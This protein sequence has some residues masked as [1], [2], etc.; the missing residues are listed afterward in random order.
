MEYDGH[1]PFVSDC[2]RVR[3]RFGAFLPRPYREPIE[4]Q[5][6]T[7]EAVRLL[8]ERWNLDRVP[9]V[10]EFDFEILR[11]AVDQVDRR[12]GSFV[13]TP[14]RPLGPGLGGAVP[15][16]PDVSWNGR[17]WEWSLTSAESLGE[18]RDRIAQD[19]DLVPNDLP[20]ELF[21]QLRACPDKAHDLG[22]KLRDL[23]HGLQAH[24]HWL[25]LRL[26]PQPDQPLGVAAIAS[27]ETPPPDQR[28]VR[29]AVTELARSMRITLP[30]LR[31][32]R[33]RNPRKTR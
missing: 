29:R 8:A 12:F 10:A 31:V 4:D 2:R 16:N 15:E 3:E 9:Q 22:W 6:A 17:R 18:F 7:R 24:V 33:P 32:G 20:A 19:L 5:I 25:F 14:F 13:A 1:E 21:D 23:P 11:Y 27:R 30:P 26:C 28:T